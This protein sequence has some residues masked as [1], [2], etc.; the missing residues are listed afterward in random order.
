MLNI[1]LFGPPGVGKGTQAHFLTNE[2]YVQLSTGDLLREE[3]TSGSDLGNKIKNI[4]EEGSF[5]EDVFIMDIVKGFLQKHS[6]APG[7]LYDGIPRTL[8]QAKAL[9]EVLFTLGKNIN[10]VI[11]FTYEVESLK[12]RVVNRCLC[13][14]CGMLFNRKLDPN[15]EG[16][17]CPECGGKIFQRADDTIETFMKRMELYEKKTKPLLMFYREKGVLV[18]VDGMESVGDVRKNIYKNIQYTIR[19]LD[20]KENQR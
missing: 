6:K 14:K 5:P 7:I 11:N 15:I 13:K 18:D 2:K 19:K 9:G 10:L 17:P 3:I 20:A 4:V 12:E 16:S 8:L 1:I